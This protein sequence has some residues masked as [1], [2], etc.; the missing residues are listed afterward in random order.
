MD[1]SDIK[2]AKDILL[3]LLNEQELILK[4]EGKMPMVVV[5]ELGDSAVNL[6]VRFWARVEDFWN[7]KFYTVEEAKTRL[8]SA[9]ISIP[10]PQR[11]VHI[12]KEA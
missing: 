11:D 7:I 12:V 9:G 1:D 10:F 4:E 3:Q 8:E 2:M 6:S 5:T